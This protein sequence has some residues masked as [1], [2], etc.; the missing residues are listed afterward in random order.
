MSR[1][2][3]RRAA[4]TLALRER[5]V[6]YDGAMGTS[7]QRYR[8]SA[9]D[10]GGERYEGCNDYLCITKPSI[11]E[12]IHCS[13]L[14]AGC[15]V[16]ETNSFRSNRI[17]LAEYGL[18]RKVLEINRAAAEL[19]RRVAD[20]YSLPGEQKF[21]AGSMGPSGK[22]PSSLDPTLGD[23]TYGELVEVFRE[24]AEG[25]LLG[26]VDVLLIETSQDILEV[27]AA[28]EGAKRAMEGT[29]IRAAIQAQV[30]LDVTGRMLLGTDVSAALAIIEPLGVDAIGLN[31]STG[32]DYMREP[33]RYLTSHTL[34]PVSAIPN[35]GLPKNVGGQ[36]VYQMEPE[37]MAEMLGNFVREFG[38]N[39]VGGCCGTTPRHIELLVKAVKGTNPWK[40]R[41]KQ[42][43]LSPRIASAMQ[44][45]EMRQEPKPLL[46]GE[47]I[48][49]QGSR[50]VKRLLLEE[51]YDAIVDIAREQVEGG[52]HALDVCVALTERTD[53]EEMMRKVVRLLSASVNSPL[54]IDSTEPNVIKA[55]LEVYPG[56]AI[57]NSINL[58]NGLKRVEEVLPV[59]KQHGAAVVALTIDEEGMAHTAERKLAIARRILDVASGMGLKPE[60][61]IF[62]VLTFPVTTGQAELRRSAIE[63]LEG[64]R[65]VKSE[66]PGVFTI[67]GVSNISF[68]LN[69]A[70][71][72]V[73]SSV[74]LHHAV[75][76]GLDMAIINPTHITPYME[77]PEEE[78]RLADD[79]L[80][81]RSEGAL[82]GLIAFFERRREETPSREKA[83]PTLG[84][85]VYEKLYW[86]ILHRK[87]EGVEELVDEA[88][89]E[90]DPVWVL[91]HV[92]LPAMKEVGDKFGSGELILP[93]VLQSAEVMKKA[94]AR[95]E[96]Y[97]ERKEGVSKGTVVIATVFGD[98]HDIG[99]N[100]V[101][102]ILSNNGYTVVDLGKQV[103]VN[104]IID[105]AVKHNAV[106]IG[107]SALLVSTSKQMPICVQE[108]HKRGLRFPVLVG[109][110]AIH[111]RFGYRILFMEDG[112][113][114]APGVFYCKDAFEGLEVVEKLVSDERDEFVE[115]VKE[116]AR[117]AMKESFEEREKP[118]EETI[119]QRAV[120][121]APFIPKPE[122][123][124]TFV[125]D[126]AEIDIDEVI[127]Y[128]DLDTLFRLHWG[129][130]GKKGREW[131]ELVEGVFMPTLR[132]L[133]EELKKTRWLS[134]GAVYGIFPAASR[135]DE[136]VIYSPDDTR[137]EIARWKFPRQPWGKRLCLSDYFLPE[138]EGRDVVGLQVVTAGP[139]ASQRI[140]ELQKRGDFAEAYYING[141]ADQLAEG[142]A[143]WVHRRIRRELHIPETQGLRYS[144]G[145][146]ACPDLSQQEDVIRLLEA[147]RIGVSLTEG[148]QL[149]PEQST[150]ALVV[151]HPE[152]IY[153]HTG[154]EH[155]AR[156]E[157]IKEILGEL[158]LK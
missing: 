87:K 31:C 139:E 117:R 13:F 2:I 130:R 132:R 113:E 47:R 61:L 154:E 24:Q 21:V 69:E 77:I 36:A 110:A 86:H 75:E 136:I 5:V 140:E 78:R 70:A 116:N 44:A 62:D 63:T 129:G 41:P 3:D 148:F 127:G 120:K 91:N 101:G 74:F 20:R 83:E 149:V 115:G 146:P 72:K 37:P 53:E 22:L 8:L 18:E 156:E 58:E 155:R 121:P 109:G 30:T 144:W 89:K 118:E 45:V 125:V 15:D 111:R 50:K 14:E 43:D 106:A 6:V 103:P 27:K 73:L 151:H 57:V 34:L 48:N 124:G 108:L 1:G 97:L 60:D 68:G 100:L 133:E 16:I 158:R 35:A 10:F 104:T 71:R 114:Y 145:Y 138:E 131:D 119:L 55:A 54:V 38:C 96:T 80:F 126:P 93:F 28:I 40:S 90:A 137:E 112:T 122:R 147:S 11:V 92:L 153:F 9:G 29:G 64:I 107:L 141:F 59:V 123:F 49:S 84:M 17:T 79:L 23:I 42:I 12:E 32:P 88:V 25:L 82:A 128:F 7:I 67:L 19:A 135:G 26:G 85:S 46:I 142:L 65:M 4:Y 99:K 94:V 102:T 39:I 150:A 157:G 51:N 66:L 56:R 105:A 134:Y 98:V 81:D 52:A 33:V 143:E 152:A 95:L 76:A